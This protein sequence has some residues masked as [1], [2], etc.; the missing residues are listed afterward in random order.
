MSVARGLH[1][2]RYVS[3]QNGAA[4]AIAKVSPTS[5]GGSLEIISM[6]GRVSGS[7]IKPGDCLV[8]RAEVQ[9]EV[10]VGLNRGSPDGSLEASFR[11]EPIAL[12]ED[13]A[14]PVIVEPQQEIRGVTF[15][16]HVANRG[17]VTFGENQW[18]GGPDAPGVIEGLELVAGGSRLEM[19]VMVG[20]RPPRWTGWVEAGEFAGTRG[21]R[22]PLSG[23]RL[24]LHADVSAEF[25]IEA[26]AL[27]LGSLVTAKIGREVEFLSPSGIDPLVGLKLS[28][29]RVQ[30]VLNVRAGENASPVRDREPRVRVFRASTAR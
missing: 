6:P 25:E 24:K 22:I 18:A 28:V 10:L 20:S 30:N 15:V 12:S 3:F 13:V 1:A 7:L 4:P 17:D 21:R 8:L 26:E 23:I 5:L 19:Q 9:T 29:K 16:A 27:F 14:P 11:L 2:F